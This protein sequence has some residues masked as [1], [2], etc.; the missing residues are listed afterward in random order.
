LEKY[1]L[2]SKNEYGEPDSFNMTI[3]SECRMTPHYIFQKA[4]QVLTEKVDKVFADPTIELVDSDAHM[5]FVTVRGENHTF[6]NLFQV[7]VF[8]EY[9]RHEVMVDYIGYVQPHPLQEKIVFKIRFY[10]DQPAT[11]VTEFLKETIEKIKTTLSEIPVDA[12][13]SNTNTKQTPE[14]KKTTRTKAAK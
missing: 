11:K 7:A 12:L 10:E 9:V 4:V 6:G 5:W 3:E 2:F 14:K 1:R 13:L 8:N